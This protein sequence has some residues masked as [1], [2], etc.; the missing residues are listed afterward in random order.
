MA[1]KRPKIDSSQTSI[2]MFG[3]DFV[4][5]IQIR[6]QIQ[7]NPIVH[8]SHENHI[9]DSKLI[10]ELNQAV[11]KSLE[12][13]L[14]S[15][16]IHI[17]KNNYPT[18]ADSDSRESVY[19]SID[20]TSKY[21]HLSKNIYH[22]CLYQIRQS[23]FNRIN[24]AKDKIE[25]ELRFKIRSIL[26]KH[27]NLKFEELKTKNYKNSIYKLLDQY[28]K[29]QSKK[30]DIESKNRDNYSWS[31]QSA[32]QII[33]MTVEAWLDND[34]ARRD[35]DEHPEHRADYTGKP[36]LCNYLKKSEYISVF[37]NQQCKIETKN[38]LITESMNEQNLRYTRKNFVTFPDHLRIKP[39]ETRLNIKT[40]LREVR[41]IPQTM[42]GSYKVELVYKKIIDIIKIKLK[43]D[44]KNNKENK[45]TIEK[46]FKI[47]E[48]NLDPNRIIGIDTGQENVSTIADNIGKSPIIIKGGIILSTNQWFDKIGSKLYSIYY[49]QQ[50]HVQ[51]NLESF[52]Q[53]E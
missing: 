23:F 4:L 22:Q 19:Q 41:I 50:K 45:K 18:I 1:K 35:W 42:K 39:I 51:R 33:D 46:T 37:T 44:G 47:K 49:R 28:F 34:L 15:E 29:M 8:I 14:R 21:C 9:E 31:P 16:Q 32:Q 48:L 6:T 17:S 3:D 10:K 11:D 13:I 43:G 25:R 20:N 30:R 24:D 26:D 53:I 2:D 36:G 12:S 7:Q 52:P 5:D 40:D 27:K 38:V